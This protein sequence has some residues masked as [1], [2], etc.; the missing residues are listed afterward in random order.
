[1]YFG[2]DPKLVNDWLKLYLAR[3]KLLHSLAFFQYRRTLPGA[4]VHD[5]K[6]L[7]LDRQQHLLTVL[8]QIDRMHKVNTLKKA[9]KIAIDFDITEVPKVKIMEMF[10]KPKAMIKEDKKQKS[11]RFF[12]EGGDFKYDPYANF[13][14]R[15]YMNLTD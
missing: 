13:Q 6:E 9:G 7:F 15:I 2:Y 1:M 8:S 12:V 3:G 10:W 5:L 11:R 4:Y 14:A